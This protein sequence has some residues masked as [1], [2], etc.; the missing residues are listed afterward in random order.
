M[1]DSDTKDVDRMVSFITHE[2]QEKVTELR[3][4]ANEEY[5][6]EKARIISEETNRIKATFDNKIKIL[7]H[8]RILER[9]KLVK[10]KR[11]K[12]LEEKEEIVK[13]VIE[14]V[15]K[16]LEGYPLNDKLIPKNINNN[17]FVMYCSERD[18]NILTKHFKG[19][20]YPLD[21]SLIGGVLVCS[22][23]KKEIWDNSY[24]TRLDA[25]LEN[26]MKIVS[27]KLFKK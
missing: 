14:K 3:I 22:K 19:D 8:K 24:Q 16:K 2:A 15:K 17:D 27:K 26:H 13:S 9:S 18:Q 25:F 21:K 12:I 11:T 1:V 6:L 4:K 20:V 10:L 7:E 23:D 5:N